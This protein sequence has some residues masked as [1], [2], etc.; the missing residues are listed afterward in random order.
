MADWKEMIKNNKPVAGVVAAVAV[1]LVAVIVV[2]AVSNSKHAKEIEQ[3]EVEKERM[4]LEY[5]YA[6]L[7]EQYALYEGQKLILK[8]D[9]LIERLE[10]EQLKVQRLY[11]ELKSEKATNAARIAELR[12]ELET[13]RGIMRVYVAQIDSLNRENKTLRDENKKQRRTIA[14]VKSQNEQ[15]ISQ[16]DSLTEKVIIASKLDAVGVK[17]T[18]LR[19]NGKLAKKIKQITKLEISF[20]IAKNVTASTGEKHVYARIRKPDGD[21]LIKNESDVFPFEGSHI[22]Y[23]C[24]K[25]V[26]YAGEEINGV[27]MYWDV[28]EFLYPGEYEVEIFADNYLIGSGVFTLEK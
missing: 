17:V 11:E 23:S 24:R 26:E 5:E 25:V 4:Q 18:P 20:S 27:A 13:L 15:L 28:E 3:L 10:A 1:V 8:N 16:R 14:N 6:D 9:S 19:K 12:A 7:A 2:L 21:I 22:P